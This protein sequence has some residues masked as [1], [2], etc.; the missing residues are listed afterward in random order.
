MLR[1]KARVAFCQSGHQRKRPGGSSTLKNGAE[2][3]YIATKAGIMKVKND[4]FRRAPGTAY[5]F[6]RRLQ[7]RRMRELSCIEHQ[8]KVK[9]KFWR[10]AP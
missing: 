9:N 6:A 1:V 4:G 10:T 3:V 2:A 5:H 8:Y 7:R